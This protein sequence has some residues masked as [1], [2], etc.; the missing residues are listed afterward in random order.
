MTAGGDDCIGG[1]ILKINICH[2]LKNVLNKN[3]I[4][5]IKK[6]DL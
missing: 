4:I 3:I 2:Y 6:T 5:I 1:A